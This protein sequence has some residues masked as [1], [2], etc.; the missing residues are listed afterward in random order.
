MKSSWNVHGRGFFLPCLKSTVV[1]CVHFLRVFLIYFLITDH[2]LLP[3]GHL[4]PW[5]LGPPAPRTQ[6][7]IVCLALTLGG[8]MGGVSPLLRGATP[9]LKLNQRRPQSRNPAQTKVR[10]SPWT[11]GSAHSLKASTVNSKNH[12]FSALHKH[13]T[14]SQVQDTASQLI[15]SIF[16]L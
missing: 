6:R 8:G 2:F 16:T 3:G 7:L 10:L 14:L 13:Y 15:S 5:V 11:A 4:K 1:L 9:K 12:I